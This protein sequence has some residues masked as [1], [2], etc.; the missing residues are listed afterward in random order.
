MT[1]GNATE[2]EDFDDH[3][4]YAR[5]RESAATFGRI[6]ERARASDDARYL[7][8]LLTQLARAEG[9]MQRFAQAHALLDEAQAIITGEMSV[10]RVRHLL[11]RGRV[12]NSAGDREAARPLFRAAWDL[13]R[14]EGLDFHAVDAAHML[15]I[16]ENGEEK[17]AWNVAACAVAETTESPRARRW[18]GALYNNRG[19]TLHELGRLEE[20]LAVFEKRLEH[21]RAHDPRAAEIAVARWSIAKTLRLLGRID[22][23]LG[24][25]EDLVRRDEEDG[26]VHEELGECLLL[27]DRSEEARPHFARAHALLED[28]PWLKRDEAERLERLARLGRD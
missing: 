12:F 6:L 28:D 22:E 20:A 9:L 8:V 1:R 23:A 5:P 13:A 26:Y 15:E 18:L 4:D 11:E 14:A 19:W 10:P 3:W 27:L 24:I 21:L 2:L 7:A 25:Q 17:L 16:A